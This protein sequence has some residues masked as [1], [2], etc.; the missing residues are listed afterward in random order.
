M[1]PSQGD[2]LAPSLPPT[3]PTTP[4]LPLPPIPPY[5]YT[6]SPPRINV[7]RLTVVY[8][9]YAVS[10]A[11]KF[12]QEDINISLAIP[13]LPNFIPPLKLALHLPIDVTPSAS[14]FSTRSLTIFFLSFLTTSQTPLPIFIDI[15]LKLKTV[16][17]E[18]T[19]VRAP[20]TRTLRSLLLSN[21]PRHEVSTDRLQSNRI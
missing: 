18:G 12:K 13:R 20:H 5:I 17:I 11:H 16:L 8:G 14:Y 6:L 21:P 19:L 1:P 3:P 9:Q 15:T 7:L 4:L 2:T 10:W